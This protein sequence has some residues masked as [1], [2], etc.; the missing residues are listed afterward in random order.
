MNDAVESILTD[1][2]WMKQL[3]W[4]T[5]KPKEEKK[6]DQMLVTNLKILS[7]DSASLMSTLWKSTVLPDNSSTRSKLVGFFSSLPVFR[8]QHTNENK[9]SNIHHQHLHRRHSLKCALSNFQSRSHDSI[10]SPDVSKFN[11]SGGDDSYTSREMKNLST[12]GLF[13]LF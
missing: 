12:I 4:S 1:K 3:F 8:I 13:H 2:R 7:R 5:S 6:E 10:H 9:K 11:A